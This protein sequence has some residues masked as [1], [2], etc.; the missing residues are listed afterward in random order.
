MQL[1]LQSFMSTFYNASM[2]G[3]IDPEIV[4]MAILTTQSA[5]VSNTSIYLMMMGDDMDYAGY[6]DTA[7]CGYHY[8]ISKLNG[9]GSILFNVPY[10]VVPIVRLGPNIG[11]LY[12]YSRHFPNSLEIDNTLSVLGHELAETATDPFINAYQSNNELGDFCSEVRGTSTTGTFGGK[13]VE[14]NVLAGGQLYLIQTLYL[15][16]KCINGILNL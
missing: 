7:G 11:C 14:Y 13:F 15:N 5:P 9:D 2:I 4:L 1:E 8:T 3:T 16:G 10:A 12:F 6:G